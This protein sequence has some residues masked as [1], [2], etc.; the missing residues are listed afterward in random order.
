MSS[1]LPLID[2][3]ARRNAQLEHR[4]R[5]AEQELARLARITAMGEFAASLAHEVS[6]PLAAMM[7]NA[8]AGLHH[9]EQQRTESACDAFKMVMHAGA[10]AGGVLRSIRGMA[11]NAP[12]S[13]S[14]FALDEAVLEVLR[15]LRGELHKHRVE[16]RTQF[17]LGHGHALQLHADRVQLQQVMMN[18]ILNA[19]HA[20]SGVE[21]ARLLLVRTALADDSGTV[22]ISVED[23]GAGIP[24]HIAGRVFEP[25]F[26]TKPGGIGIGLGICRAIVGA[27]GGRIWSASRQPHGTAFHVSLPPHHKELHHGH[28]L[29]PDRRR[30]SAD[31]RRP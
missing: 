11:A 29:H 2:V 9:L 14:L 5:M 4:L 6:Q 17:G 26:S 19:I 13:P 31:T 22:R 25:M 7:L 18:L 21:R 10:A 28:H 27:H 12:A 23:N 20:M 1:E 15:L 3:L 30:S 16:V 8:E 24:A